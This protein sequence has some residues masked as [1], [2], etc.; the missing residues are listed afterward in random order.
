[1]SSRSPLPA[2]PLRGATVLITRAAGDA[3]PLRER[4]QALGAEVVEAPA[5]EIRPPADPTQLDTALSR[6]NAYDWLAF[7]SRVAVR[8]V[9]ER[10][11]ALDV[12]VPARLRVAAVGAA[13][14]EALRES[15]ITV[16]CVGDDGT[17]AGLARALRAL[18][19]GG[20]SVLI[21]QGDLARDDL[22]VGLRSAGARVE[23]V[24]AYR[25]VQPDLASGV[26]RMLQE[27][28]IDAVLFASPSAA[29]NLAASLGDDTST[30]TRV[31]VVCIGPTTA[32]AVRELGLEPA[33][34]AAERSNEGMIEALLRLQMGDRTA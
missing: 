1:M 23:T 18:G 19:I 24:I 2:K 29:R 10:M 28:R 12:E 14:A 26:R 6:L 20:A 5:I 30:L 15:G 7:T 32:E 11:A 22:A 33:A 31:R 25:T 13:T 27:G 17:A 16:A 4:L 34:V 8:S 9:A 3:G 21:P